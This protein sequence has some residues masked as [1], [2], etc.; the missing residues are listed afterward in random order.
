MRVLCRHG[1]MSFYPEAAGD[2]SMFCNYFGSELVREDDFWTFERLQN[3]PSYSIKG[4]PYLGKTAKVSYAGRPWE[5]MKAN[6]M[7][8]NIQTGE[9]ADKSEISVAPINPP[10]VAFYFVSDVP[11][12]QPGTLHV[13][14]R[15][16][17]SYDG[18]FIQDYFQ[19]RL[20][21]FDYD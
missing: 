18:Y 19:L 11:L 5:V 2:L 6:D 7:V 8:F 10:R 1:H 16:I 3:A 4:N 13:S 12:I 9:M 15:R 21:G 17:L 20:M 14:G